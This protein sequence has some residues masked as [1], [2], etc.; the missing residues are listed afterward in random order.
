MTSC[1]VM[2]RLRVPYLYSAPIDF[3]VRARTRSA[4]MATPVAPAV[5]ACMDV[6]RAGDFRND[7]M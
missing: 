3:M 1:E 2:E 6:G 4:G 7:R 5:S